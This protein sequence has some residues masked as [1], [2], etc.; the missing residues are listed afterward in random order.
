V[1]L[2]TCEVEE[3]QKAERREYRDLKVLGLGRGVEEHVSVY[4]HVVE[5]SGRAL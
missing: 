4:P 5:G 1:T 3:M 2:E